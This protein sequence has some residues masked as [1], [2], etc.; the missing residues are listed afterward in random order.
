[1]SDAPKAQAVLAAR[2]S[3]RSKRGAI[4]EP[5]EAF[6]AVLNEQTILE[7]GGMKESKR[8]AIL[9]KPV[10]LPNGSEGEVRTRREYGVRLLVEWVEPDGTTRT[11]WVDEKDAKPLTKTQAAE[12]SKRLEAERE[13]REVQTE[14]ALE[15]HETMLE[16][17]AAQREAS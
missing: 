10:R 4:V 9:G 2:R 17:L 1:V 3:A 14:L 11:V 7:G 5:D 12:R 6:H 13:A 16:G 15:P 8:H